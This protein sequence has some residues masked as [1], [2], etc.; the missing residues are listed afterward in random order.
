MR[1]FFS[2][3]LAAV[4]AFMVGAQTK[5]QDPKAL[6][7]KLSD[8][9]DKREEVRRELS[10][11]N[12][13]RNRVKRDIRAVDADLTRVSGEIIRTANRL[14]SASDRREELVGELNVATELMNEYRDRV[15]DRLRQ[16]YRQPDHSVLTLLVG[17]D[18]V[19]DFAER[20]TLLERIAK[21]DRELFDGLK[22]LKADI[23]GKKAEQEQLIGEIAQLKTQHEQRAG[24]LE[25]IQDEK[26]EVLQDLDKERR[27]LERE[28]AEFD[29]AS[30]QLES[31][32][33]AIQAKASGKAGALKFDGQ[34]IKP[35]NGPITSGFGR[36]YHPI[37]KK[38]RPHE[39]VDIGAPNRSAISAAANGTVIK[40]GWMSGY[41]NTVVIDHGNGISTLYGHCSVIYVKEG[42]SV[43]MGSKVAAVGSTGLATGPHLHFEVRKNG[44]PVNPMG[45][46]G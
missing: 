34:M 24:E 36:R 46:I 35:A 2:I 40:A 14:E 13:Q 12:A 45:Y 1:A 38:Y 39:G 30:K 28:F 42:Q 33:R 17:A 20:K 16:M 10:K 15:E 32:I 3:L 29:R 6:N 7:D 18:S 44:T 31:Q 11:V 9:K 23:E 41:G 8:V 37:L 4:F 5:T 22:D 43:T 21:H 26:K 27:R 19:G 25:Q